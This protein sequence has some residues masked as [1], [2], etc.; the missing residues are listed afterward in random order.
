[1]ETRKLFY[2]DPHQKEFTAKVLSCDKTEK[3]WEILLD[4][5][6]FYPEG[7][8]QACD[9]G[10]LSDAQVL[11]VQERGADIVHYCNAPL[12]VGSEVAGRI[13]WARRFDLMQQHTG[14]HIVSG[15]IHRRYFCCGAQALGSWTPVV[16]AYGLR[17]CSLQALEHL[18]FSSCGMQ[19]Q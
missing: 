14:E 13:D 12:T 1:M 17:S 3:G 10:F 19:A 5:T 18:G 2:E 7:G 4:Q 11:D 6:A 9:I 8:G 15:I 16:A